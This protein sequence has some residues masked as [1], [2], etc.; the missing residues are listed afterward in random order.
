M[1]TSVSCI[2]SNTERSIDTASSPHVGRRVLKDFAVFGKGFM[3][4][5]EREWIVSLPSSAIHYNMLADTVET[6]VKM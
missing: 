4:N 3:G 2:D 5:K 1:S 6:N